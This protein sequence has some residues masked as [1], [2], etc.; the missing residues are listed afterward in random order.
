[1]GAMVVLQA[2]LSHG[3]DLPVVPRGGRRERR[4]PVVPAYAAEAAPAGTTEPEHFLPSD[5]SMD[6]NGTPASFH[7]VGN[8]YRSVY[9]PLQCT[10]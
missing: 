6:D 10:A 4:H 8:A 2:L 3:D 9:A 1:M 5:G 7:G